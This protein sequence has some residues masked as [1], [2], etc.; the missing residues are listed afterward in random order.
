MKNTFFFCFLSFFHSLLSFF[1]GFIFFLFSVLQSNDFLLVFL[2]HF[3]SQ[4]HR[5]KV[6]HPA[7]PPP[8]Q[9]LHLFSRHP[10]S[11]YQ[12]QL[13]PDCDAINI[14]PASLSIFLV[15]INICELSMKSEIYF[16]ASKQLIECQWYFFLREPT[17]THVMWY[18]FFVI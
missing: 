14:A 10:S 3:L 9:Q 1:L 6:S 2:F 5:L 8:L 11:N 16:R 7:S 4:W 12:L 15:S 13:A 18:L 17:M